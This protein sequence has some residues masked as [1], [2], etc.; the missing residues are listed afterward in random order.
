ME[1]ARIGEQHYISF[2]SKNFIEC[3]RALDERDRD[4]N[5]SLGMLRVWEVSCDMNRERSTILKREVFDRSDLEHRG[6]RFYRAEE[7]AG[8]E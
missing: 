8:E 7:R 4:F 1:Q 3:T 6:A 5:T 2:D